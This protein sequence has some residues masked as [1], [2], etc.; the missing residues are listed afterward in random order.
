MLELHLLGTGGTMPLPERPLTALLAR[1]NGKSYLIDCGEG[2]QIAIRKNGLSLKP[3]DMIF[4][5]HFHADHIAGLPGLLLTMGKQGRNE[6]VVMVGPSGLEHI[7]K[8][9]CVVAPELPFPLKFVEITDKARAFALGELAVTAFAV[10]HSVPCFGYSIEL[11]RAGRF[12]PDKARALRLEPRFWSILQSGEN[13]ELDGKIYTPDMVMGAPRKGLKATYCTDSRPTAGI[14]EYAKNSDLFICEGM[15]GD[16]EKLDSAVEKKHML[17]RE[18]AEIAR[19]AQ[20][21]SLWLTHY[22][23]SLVNPRE[24]LPYVREI[25]PNTEAP[26]ESMSIDLVFKD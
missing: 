11:A 22:S 9:L 4:F 10:D 12:N 2:T 26:D 14:I 19:A 24:Y 23:P 25:F 8:S 5:T 21:E 13:V 20:V 3:I 1:Y 16:E 18:A 17:F 15:Y 6:P 7:V